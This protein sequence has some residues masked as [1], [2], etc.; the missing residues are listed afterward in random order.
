M[1]RVKDRQVT[2]N[3]D[4]LVAA[5]TALL[6]RAP[7][8][9]QRRRWEKA[10]AAGSSVGEELLGLCQSSAYRSRLVEESR[11][12]GHLGDEEFVEEMYRRLFRRE[13]D[14]G[15]LEFY[16]GQLGTGTSRRHV[17]EVLASSDEHVNRVVAEAYP[18][19]DLVSAHPDRY[20]RVAIESGAPEVLCFKAE[21]AADFEW[22]LQ[23]IADHDYYD[24]PGIW[25]YS[26]TADKRIMAEILAAFGPQRVLDLGCANGTVM[27]CL[28][29]LGVG[30]DGIE[31][32][33]ASARKAFPEIRP[34]IIVGDVTALPAD[35]T[36]D[37]VAGLDIF[38]HVTPADLDKL[39]A[40]IAD[41]VQPGGFLYVNVPAFG[42][43]DVFGT[44][45]DMYVPEWRQAA[46][47]RRPFDRLHTDEA[48]FPLHGHL[49]WAAADW[50]QEQFEAVGFTREPRIEHVIHERYGAYFAEASPARQA[51]FVLSKSPDEAV[52]ERVVARVR[53]LERQPL[54]R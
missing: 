44:V 30:A 25:G 28:Y 52:V 9:R 18:L 33:A 40:Q 16:A 5:H 14:R 26:L 20:A 8:R 29:D 12:L 50:W 24:R 48:G 46:A 53:A 6:G 31:L 39:I 7:D 45:F 51:F 32:S 11:T 21:S 10:I 47:A 35:R 27:K 43:D 37:L 38:E 42:H 4:V 49:V 23:Q 1:G 36:Y 13:A 19:P 15:G 22:I 17:V 41:V 2:D 54:P 34:N 3:L